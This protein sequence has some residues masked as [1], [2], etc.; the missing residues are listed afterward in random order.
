MKYSTAILRGFKK[1]GGAQCVNHLYEGHDIV[2]TAVCVNG[3]ALL[4]LHGSAEFDDDGPATAALSDMSDAFLAAWGID[5]VDLNNGL[6]D[7]PGLPWEH[8][9]GMARAAGV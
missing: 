5:P 7:M 3:A 6:G 8:I 9:Y 2:P 1:V 4:A